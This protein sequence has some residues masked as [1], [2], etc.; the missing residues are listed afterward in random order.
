MLRSQS[1]S[2]RASRFDRRSV[3]PSSSSSRR[4][5]DEY[6]WA[7]RRLWPRCLQGRKDI[8]ECRHAG[9]RVR[10]AICKTSL[11]RWKRQRL[12][13]HCEISKYPPIRHFSIHIRTKDGARVCASALSITL[14][15]ALLPPPA[16]VLHHPLFSASHTTGLVPCHYRYDSRP[17]TLT[18]AARAFAGWS[19]FK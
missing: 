9:R 6:A 2:T 16:H 1:S 7:T 13:I 8:D 15:E 12:S 10:Q 5:D 17:S 4:D 19:G 11:A 3:A 14:N 18:Q